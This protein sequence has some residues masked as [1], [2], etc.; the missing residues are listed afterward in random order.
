VI[1]PVTRI[2]VP[3]AAGS[4]RIQEGTGG[5]QNKLENNPM[6][7]PMHQSP[8]WRREVELERATVPRA[9]GMGVGSVGCTA[10]TAALQRAIGTL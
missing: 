8:R 4:S 6:R 9:G 5:A 2:C 1:E 3:S 7:W 10:R